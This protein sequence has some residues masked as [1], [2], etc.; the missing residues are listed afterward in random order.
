[1][2]PILSKEQAADHGFPG[3]VSKGFTSGDPS[4]KVTF[5]LFVVAAKQYFLLPAPL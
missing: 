2:T 4:P 5:G 3:R 1:M